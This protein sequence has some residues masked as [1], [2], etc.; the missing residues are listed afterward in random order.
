VKSPNPGTTS[1]VQLTSVDAR[2]STDVWAVGAGSDDPLLLRWNGEKWAKT[3]PPQGLPSP[4]YSTG[5]VGDRR[6][7]RVH[8]R[9]RIRLRRPRD[10]GPAPRRRR[11]DSR[12]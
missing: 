12:V 8:D 11:L 3:D 9:V 6:P 1:L 2:T 10:G 4:T 7:E 5:V